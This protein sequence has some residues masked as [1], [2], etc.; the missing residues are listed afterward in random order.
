MTFLR[1]N[2]ISASCFA[3]TIL[4]TADCFNFAILSAQEAQVSR[5]VSDNLEELFRKR[6]H[7]YI[8]SDRM[9]SSFKLNG[10]DRKDVAIENGLSWRVHSVIK[11]DSEEG[12]LWLITSVPNCWN[13]DQP[14][15]FIFCKN[16]ACHFFLPAENSL[17]SITREHSETG[18]EFIRLGLVV[19]RPD[20]WVTHVRRH[21]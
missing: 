21:R 6:L 13:A 12:S 19:K 5:E 18:T 3:W 20:T 1:F 8:V 9:L 2:L 16:T 4:F 10:L 11:L 14:Q 7:S 15:A 17:A